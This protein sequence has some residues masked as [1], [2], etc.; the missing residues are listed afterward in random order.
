MKT[1]SRELLRISIQLRWALLLYYDDDDGCIAEAVVE[2][3]DVSL[4]CLGSFCFIEEDN[5]RK[6]YGMSE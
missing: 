2:P 4:L 1:R 6:M 3:D 5:L